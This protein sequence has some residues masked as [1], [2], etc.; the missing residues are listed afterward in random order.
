[1]KDRKQYQFEIDRIKDAVKQN[2]LNRSTIGNFIKN[3][4]TS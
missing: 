4:K 2:K 1:M 3:I